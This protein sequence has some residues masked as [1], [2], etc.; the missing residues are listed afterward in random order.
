MQQ[1]L[2]AATGWDYDLEE[3]MT[4]GKRIFSLKRIINHNLGS[5]ISDDRLPDFMLKGFSTGGT[6]GF[7]PDLKPLLEGAYQEHGWDQ[8]TGLPTETALQEYNLDFTR[9]DLG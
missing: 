9:S 6:L 8:S 2:N 5:T 7:E 4:A 1:A 3:L